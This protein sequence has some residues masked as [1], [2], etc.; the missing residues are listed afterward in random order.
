[1][2]LTSGAAVGSGDRS[3]ALGDRAWYVLR[4]VA[5]AIAYTASGKLGLHFA[6]ASHSVTAIWPPT[7]I[8]LAALV[9]GGYRLWPAVTLGALLANVNTGVPAVTVLGIVIG[10]TLEAL[11]GAFLLRRVGGFRPGLERVRD[12]ISLVVFGAV[13]STIVSATIGVASLRTGGVVSWASVPSLWRTWWLGDMGGDLIVAP[14][15]L[16][17][18]NYRRYRQL[19]GQ[20]F[21]AVILIAALTGVSVLVFSHPTNVVYSLFPLLIWA[22]LRFW[23]PG[24]AVASLLTGT[25]AVVLT[26]H[27]TGPFALSGPDDRLL[28]AQTFVAVLGV[29]A[30]VLAAV[31]SERHRAEEA[32][33]EIANTLQRSLLPDAAPSVPG[34]EIA[35]LYRPAGAAEVEVGGD[36]YDFFATPDGWIVIIGDVAGKGVRAAAM[37]GLMRH[38]ARF[39]SQAESGP[40][41]ILARLDDALAQRPAMSLCSALCISVQPDHLLVSSAGHPGPVVV[42]RDGRVREIGGAGP[43]LGLVSGE[44]WPERTV[45]VGPE[46]TVLLYTDGVTDTKGK[47]ERFGKPRLTELLVEH[48]DEAPD[49]LLAELE[50]ALDR[51]QLGPQS[52]DTAALALRLERSA[53]QG[54]THSRFAT[55]RVG[56]FRLTANAPPFRL[57]TTL[58][59]NRAI[60]KLAGEL[61]YVTAERLAEA[62][63]RTC[64]STHARLVL[65]LAD[66]TFVDSAGLR[67]LLE[68][69]RRARERRLALETVSPPEDVRAV[70]RL[71]GVDSLGEHG[72][73]PSE[74]SRDL[75]YPERVTLELA[76][77]DQAPRQARAEVREAIAGRV[78]QSESEGAVLITSELV[79]NAVVHPEH[80]TGATIGLRIGTGEG[81]IRV[82]VSDSGHGFE[83]GEL[84][85]DDN[86]AGGRG[87]VIVDRGATRWGTSNNHRFSVWFELASEHN[88]DPADAD[89]GAT[90]EP[91]TGTGSDGDQHRTDHLQP[92]ETTVIERASR[93]L[94]PARPRGFDA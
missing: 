59:G 19:P 24:A 89:A 1:M 2:G 47:A 63:D 87:L 14:A 85:R 18:A 88:P 71:S 78:S 36:F 26:A 39:V 35:T 20:P 74:E 41:A 75:Q 16:I 12:V 23:Q 38:G 68:I 27:G 58:M 31:T 25:V 62:Y 93:G 33:R 34:W 7:G 60:I 6:F 8:A 69:E 90:P 48:A 64:H 53:G 44:S 51:F 56:G 67:A 21:E 32:E 76:V 28:L 37:A 57:Q 82:E 22:A 46:E 66:V 29:T 84:G 55:P 10:N 81:R 77:N 45:R 17:A 42:R 9:L 43:L 5:V 50:S 94:G 83:P 73:H 3:R 70:F 61:D 15:I 52:D 72:E 79:T 49:A 80:Q 4:I 65:D 30:L 86:T 54:R 91:A 92:T 13:I 11:T 40:A